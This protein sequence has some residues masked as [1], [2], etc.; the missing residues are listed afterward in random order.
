MSELIQVGTLVEASE[1]VPFGEQD[2]ASELSVDQL[3]HRTGINMANRSWSAT[4]RRI[5]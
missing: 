5:A 4:P 2:G 1:V 3:G